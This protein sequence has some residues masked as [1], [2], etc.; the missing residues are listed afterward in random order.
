MNSKNIKLA[1]ASNKYQI[2]VEK[3][4]MHFFPHI[5][6]DSVYGQRDGIPHKP[7]PTVIF[8]IIKDTGINANDILYVGDSGVDM[9]TAIN[10]KVD[11]C[12]VTWGLRPKSELEKF[13]P[14]YIIDHPSQILDII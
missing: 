5:V 9:Q 4:V 10:A 11:S 8:D 12:G 2:A 3:M 7:D 1:V 14:T 13:N 6:F